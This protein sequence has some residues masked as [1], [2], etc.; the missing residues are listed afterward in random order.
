MGTAD[1]PGP[2]RSP[3]VCCPRVKDALPEPGR[4]V[5]CVAVPLPSR[6]AVA[7]PLCVLE[8]VL[9]VWLRACGCDSGLRLV[10]VFVVALRLECPEGPSPRVPDSLLRSVRAEELAEPR[11]LLTEERSES[12]AAL[13]A[14]VMD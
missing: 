4:C 7:V 14:F 8:I 11:T 13:Q 10:E 2:A 3:P 1:P 5:S 6:C 9:A 12:G